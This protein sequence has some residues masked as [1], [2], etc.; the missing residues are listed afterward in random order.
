MTARHRAARR[1]R[2]LFRTLF[3]LG[4]LT[5]ASALSTCAIAYADQTL[6]P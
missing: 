6:L 2:Y 1:P 3:L 5:L 4:M